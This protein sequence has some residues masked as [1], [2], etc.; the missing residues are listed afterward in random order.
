MKN[1][2]S[3]ILIITCVF[4]TI[5]FEKVKGNVFVD[6]NKNGVYDPDETKTP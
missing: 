3:V 5:A 1:I 4:N 6:V 2:L